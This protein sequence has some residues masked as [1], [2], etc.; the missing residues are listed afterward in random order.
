MEAMKKEPVW[1]N[2]NHPNYERWKRS[3]SLKYERGR[4]V[5]QILES[6]IEL[7]EKT[8]LDAGS[9]EGGTSAVLL[10]DNFVV[11]SDISLVRLQRQ[12][13]DGI[14]SLKI[15]CNAAEHCFAEG[16]FDIII[17]QDVI[18]HIGELDHLIE[19]IRLSLKPDGLLYLSTP[20]KHSIINFLS[21]PHWGLPFVSLM[22]RETLARKVLKFLRKDDAD[23]KDLA[24]LLS[25][26]DIRRLFASDF[27][28]RLKTNFVANQLFQGHKG[29][30]WLSLIHI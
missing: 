21:D 13:G 9:G 19:E 8:I 18:E 25:L 4:L 2:K 22:K 7:K 29:I 14:E 16:V 11:S 15:L 17:L 1:L 24:E 20:N 5:K 3:R 23:R 30:L 10:N 26:G 6:E 27:D 12:A 28:L